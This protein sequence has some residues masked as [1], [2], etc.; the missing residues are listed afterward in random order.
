M[1]E[2][3]DELHQLNVKRFQAEQRATATSNWSLLWQQLMLLG[4]QLGVRNPPLECDEKLFSSTEVIIYLEEVKRILSST[5]SW[6]TATHLQRKIESCWKG[7]AHM[8]NGI[9]MATSKANTSTIPT[10]T[11]GRKDATAATTTSLKD[12]DSKRTTPTPTPT[13][14]T[15]TTIPQQGHGEEDAS[16]N[17][18]DDL[19][20]NYDSAV[21]DTNNSSKVAK[22]GKES[23]RYRWGG[24]QFSATSPSYTIGKSWNEGHLLNWQLKKSVHERLQHCRIAESQLVPALVERDAVVIT[25]FSILYILRGHSHLISTC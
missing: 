21:T 4:Q 22:E 19:P 23:N 24:P 14:T 5:P 8:C 3:K 2:G 13:P 7:I 10:T 9:R 18:T 17:S 25:S 12:T 1:N 20:T 11:N 16:D 6:K 15:T